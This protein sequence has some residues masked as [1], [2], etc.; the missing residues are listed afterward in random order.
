MVEMQTR[1][2]SP[3][4]L[5]DHTL[6]NYAAFAAAAMGASVIEKH[7]TFSKRMYGSV[8]QYAAEPHDFAE[9]VQ[10]VRAIETILSNPVNKDD[11]TPFRVMKETFEKSLVSLMD[12]PKGVRITEEMIGAKKPGTG[13]PAARLRAFIGRKAARDI[14]ADELLREEDFTK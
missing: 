13:I 6:T 11:L 3:V 12:I 1:Y 7:L 4:G 9:M 14:P 10:G 5:S 2:H 8:A